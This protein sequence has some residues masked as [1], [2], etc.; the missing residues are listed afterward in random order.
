MDKKSAWVKLVTDPTERKVFEA[1]SD[2]KWDF[3]TIE[4]ISNS[5]SVPA[6]QISDIVKK[7]EGK[8][9]RKSLVPDESGRNLFTST[10]TQPT[11][12]EILDFARI[13]TSK[14]LK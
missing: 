14:T 3:R 9:I 7:Y 13:L 12:S 11:T 2:P 8:L 5:T 6:A 4:G 10:S 1:L